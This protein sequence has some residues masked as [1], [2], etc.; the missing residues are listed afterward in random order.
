MAS[1]GITTYEQLRLT[2]TAT[3]HG[4]CIPSDWHHGEIVEYFSN[5][6]HPFVSNNRLK[7]HTVLLLDDK[8]KIPAY[9][10]NQDFCAGLPVT[11]SPY[12]ENCAVCNASENG[13]SSKDQPPSPSPSDSVILYQTCGT[14]NFIEWSVRG[15]PNER[16]VEVHPKTIPKVTLHAPGDH[17]GS[18]GQEHHDPHRHKLH[19]TSY[20]LLENILP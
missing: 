12:Y 3:C 17:I 10:D 19:S 11:K 7:T 15:W 5:P 9:K 16:I 1:Q 6:N 13:Y 18:N 20:N 2:H 4:G 8:Y 14:D